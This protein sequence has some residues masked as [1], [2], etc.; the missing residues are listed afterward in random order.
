MLSNHEFEQ[1]L[2]FAS[3]DQRDIAFELR[4]LVAE[5]A[6]SATEVRHSRGLTYFFAERGGPVSAGICQIGLYA[7]HV[8]L[9]FNHGAF[10]NDRDGLLEGSGL[11]KR[12]VRILSFESARWD[13]IRGLMIEAA[14]FDPRS[15]I[16]M[17]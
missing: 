4:N 16:G 14:G 2:Q 3:Q 9:A 10:L 15:L 7:D 8:R 11:A 5:I 6:P 13:E 12:F 1:C 17:G